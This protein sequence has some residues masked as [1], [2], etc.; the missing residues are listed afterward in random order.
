MGPMHRN[1]DAEPERLL[2]NLRP[3]LESLL[4]RRQVSP[5]AAA[6]LLTAALLRVESRRGP[7]PGTNQVRLLRA[8]NAACRRTAFFGR[9]GPA[10][11]GSA[12]ELGDYRRAFATV[13]ARLRRR[14]RRYELE[15]SAAPGLAAELLALSPEVRERAL[16]RRRFRSLP[17]AEHLLDESG[18]TWTAEPARGEPLA[19][20]ALSV[21]DG[22]TDRERAHHGHGR[23]ADL[24]AVGWTYVANARRILFDLRGAE[25]ALATAEG[26][27]V[28]G[29]GDPRER[30]LLLLVKGT[31][32]RAQRRFTEALGLLA[33]ATAIHRW[34]V[35]RHEEGKLLVSQAIVHDYAGDPERAIPLVHRALELIDPE[36]DPRLLLVAHHNLA[37]YFIATGRHREAEAL[38]PEVRRR[39]AAVGGRLEALLVRWLDGMLAVK[40]GRAERGEEIL[41]ALRDEYLGEG[42]AYNAAL[43]SLELVALFL[44]QRRPADASRLAA[45]LIP[46]FVS[47]DVHREAIAA[48]LALQQAAEQGAATVGLVQDVAALL[49]RLRTSGPPRAEAPS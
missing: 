9:R 14:R 1:P 4:R 27:L 42:L 31:L 2:T 18:R 5:A 15:R 21:L 36:R 35:D 29:T 8:C 45:E 23:L 19:Q 22:L 30:A 20:L 47:R 48:L 32:R 7:L 26:L 28:A 6:E 13:R 3:E 11:A 12:S 17:L 25:A 37:A 16:R 46:I 24:R 39:T 33:Q 10:A 40:L 43:V 44:D 34:T 49:R 41:A 38:L